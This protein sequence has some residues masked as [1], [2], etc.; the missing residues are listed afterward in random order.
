MTWLSDSVFAGHTFV[1]KKILKKKNNLKKKKKNWRISKF[2]SEKN[3]NERREKKWKIAG[4]L[5]LK[6]EKEKF[7]KRISIFEEKKL[8]K[9]KGKREIPVYCVYALSLYMRKNF[10]PNLSLTYTTSGAAITRKLQQKKIKKEKTT[11]FWLIVSMNW[12]CTLHVQHL[13]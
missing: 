6:E 9:K 11:N 7:T 5:V 3:K 10:N 1:K 8:K 2:K 12:C 4:F 13:N